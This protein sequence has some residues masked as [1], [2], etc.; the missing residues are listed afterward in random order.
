MAGVIAND[1]STGCPT[2]RDA[3]PLIAPDAAVI[4]A[5][6]SPTPVARPELLTVATVATD[7]LQLAEFVKICVLPSL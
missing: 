6:P 2:V 7:E 4:V 1:T 5:L 3:D